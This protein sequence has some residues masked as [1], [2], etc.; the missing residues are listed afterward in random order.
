MINNSVITENNGS[1]YIYL[2]IGAQRNIKSY[3]YKSKNDN[4]K[5]IKTNERKAPY[6]DCKIYER[7]SQLS[8]S[9]DKH[10]TL[11]LTSMINPMIRRLTQIKN[12]DDY[13]YKVVNL[14]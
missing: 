9:G 13:C 2:Q 3:L 7:L 6:L 1:K 11:Y 8:Y 12:A 4:F 10:D 14:R 5:I